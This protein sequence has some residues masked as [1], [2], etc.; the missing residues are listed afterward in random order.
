MYQH[1][2]VCI[3]AFASMHKLEL[4]IPLHMLWLQMLNTRYREKDE[5]VRARERERSKETQ[6]TK[7]LI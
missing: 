1:D 3:F 2:K 6:T 5:R 7:Q 4:L